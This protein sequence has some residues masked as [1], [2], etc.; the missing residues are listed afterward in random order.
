VIFKN[1]ILKAQRLLH[2]GMQGE[3]HPQRSIARLQEAWGKADEYKKTHTL[4]AQEREILD[5]AILANVSKP[6]S[7]SDDYF[8]SALATLQRFRAEQAEL[9]ARPVKAVAILSED[10]WQPDWRQERRL[11]LLFQPKDAPFGSAIEE[12]RFP[13]P[14]PNRLDLVNRASDLAADANDRPWNSL[15]MVS[16][17]R[18]GALAQWKGSAFDLR[19][20]NR[21]MELKGGAFT[22][23]TTISADI[24]LACTA[25]DH[26]KERLEA[27]GRDK[28]ETD[29]LLLAC[30][31]AAGNIAIP[32]RRPIKFDE[33]ISNPV[34]VDQETPR[35]W[36]EI[37]RVAETEPSPGPV[38]IEI[39]ERW[40]AVE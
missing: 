27:A 33:K 8:E 12:V 4:T 34:V 26:L 15:F 21:A 6:Y 36:F 37:I 17:Y 13:R 28:G 19:E 5:M 16:I 29:R 39:V 40:M 35:T 11:A 2:L 24:H 20:S 25:Y 31:F 22:I 1:L 3:T 23:H 32:R 10:R 38:R 14:W 7:A 18:R 30:G 9:R